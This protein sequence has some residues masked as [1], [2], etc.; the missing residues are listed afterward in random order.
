MVFLFTVRKI[1][2]FKQKLVAFVPLCSF[3]ILP[4]KQHTLLVSMATAHVTEFT[5]DANSWIDD[6]CHYWH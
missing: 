4:M 5:V 1:D 2:A 6:V 3:N